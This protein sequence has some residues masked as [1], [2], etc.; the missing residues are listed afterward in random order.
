[1]EEAENNLNK[2]ATNLTCEEFNGY[3]KGMS[4]HWFFKC[5]NGKQNNPA[6][7]KRSLFWEGAYDKYKYNCKKKP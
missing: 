6:A 7:F 5:T 2:I 4:L 1:M 3:C